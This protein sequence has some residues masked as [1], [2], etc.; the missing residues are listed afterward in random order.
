MKRFYTEA[1]VVEDAG[2]LGIAL[3]GKPARTPGKRPLIVPYRPLADAIAAEWAAQVDTVEPASMAL[4]RL[5]NSA[6]DVVADRR[7]DIIDEAARYAA[8]DLLCYRAEGPET[9]VR[10]QEE[11]WQPL[12]DWIETR[13]GARFTV[14]R[15][16]LP[17]EQSSEALEHVRGAV[18]A[19]DDFPLTA[20]HATTAASGSVVIALAVADGRLT[21]DAAFEI[22]QLDETYQIEQWGEDSESTKRRDALH[23]DMRAASRFLELCA[24]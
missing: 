6:I 15:T 8:T 9:L 2:A 16:V 18:A 1:A 4:T 10:R 24:T 17:A 23:R 21:G 11:A 14:T 7:A 5:A 3:D 13:H 19:F 20:L 12:L 22:S